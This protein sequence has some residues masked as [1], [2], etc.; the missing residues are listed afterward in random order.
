MIFVAKIYILY[1]SSKFLGGFFKNLKAD[2]RLDIKGFDDSV[3]LKR[4]SRILSDD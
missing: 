1:C 3:H 2:I 4:T